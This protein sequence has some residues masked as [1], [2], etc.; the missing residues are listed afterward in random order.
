MTDI[1]QK[2]LTLLTDLD[3]VCQREGIRYYL[4]KETAL[5]AYRDEAFF[6]SC[7]EANVAMT[8]ED[9]VRF[10]KAVRKENRPDR[11]ADSMFSNK[12]YPDFTVRYGDAGT[13]MMSL[14][15]NEASV[16]PVIAVTIHMIRYKSKHSSKIYRATRALW[17][18]CVKPSVTVA[19]FSRR[20]AVI[21]CH[22]AKNIL[23]GRLFSRNLF[24]LW[25]RIYRRKVGPNISICGSSFKFPKEL[26]A[27]AATVTLEGVTFPTF[28]DPALYFSTAY[29]NLWETCK[30]AF[31]TPS[32]SLLASSNVSYRE[33]IRRSKDRINYKAIQ[34]K[35][36]KL[37]L[38]QAKVSFYNHKING[39][40]NIVDRTQRRFAMYEKYMPMKSTL[41]QLR[42]EER[43]EEL[44]ELLKPYRSALWACY[45]K[46]LGLCF[47][48]D[49][50][51]MTMDIL[52]RE[53]SKTYVRKLRAMVPESHWEPLVITDYK[54]E[55]INY[56]G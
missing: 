35:K 9:A 27:S 13:L 53:G 42:R 45:K 49:I 18:A 50:F 46:K 6:P 44:N 32:S 34:K 39:Y 19:G 54:G 4:C 52:L 22:G 47:D 23:G 1:Q 25:V 10:I 33:Y 29:G 36:I 51:E 48:K 55:P 24:K 17:K 2:L 12:N 21:A 56:V 8:T 14:P 11:V 28:A 7:C 20:A 31:L 15:Y 40:Y 26:I 3:A 16:V 37:D 30:P 41:M 5:G 38:I 43:W